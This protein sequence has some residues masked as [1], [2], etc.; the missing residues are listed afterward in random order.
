MIL[1]EYFR[2]R[3]REELFVQPPDY[4]GR[5]VFFDHKGQIDFRSALRNH[6]DLHVFEYPEDLGGYSGSVAQAFTYQT[7]NRLSAF[8]LHI[9]QLGEIG[10]QRRDGLVGLGRY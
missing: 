1:S 6:A 8:I 9:G 7:D 2:V 3:L 4:L 10:G 5:V